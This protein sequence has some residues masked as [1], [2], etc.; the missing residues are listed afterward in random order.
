[1]NG[2][3]SPD[4]A[5]KKTTSNKL[6]T[7]MTDTIPSAQRVSQSADNISITMSIDCIVEVVGGAGFGIALLDI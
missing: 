7:R 2:T 3:S 5:Y 1:M 4:V 6:T